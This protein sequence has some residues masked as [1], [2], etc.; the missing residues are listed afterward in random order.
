M[1]EQVLFLALDAG[2]HITAT[3]AWID[4]GRSRLHR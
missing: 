2:S 3:E 4:G 1:A